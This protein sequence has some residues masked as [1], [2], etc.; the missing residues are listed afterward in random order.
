MMIGNQMPPERRNL[1]GTWMLRICKS[2][3][4]Q[5]PKLARSLVYLVVSLSLPPND[6]TVSQDMASELLKVIGTET[7]KPLDVSGTY[8]FINKTNSAAIASSILQPVESNIIDMDW[9]II[10][11]KT[12]S[13]AAQ[14][15]ISF[16]SNGKA[17]PGLALEGTLYSRME[18]VVKIL[19]YFVVM[20][21]KGT[22]M[23]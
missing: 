1:M 18:A 22:L 5:N 7:S 15:G 3:D 10:K 8:P 23:L 19:S 4:F 21:L 13:T 12:Y 14:K 2:S 6:L 20:N 11:L 17:G 9:I 16:D